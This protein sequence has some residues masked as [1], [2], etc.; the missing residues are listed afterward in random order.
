MPALTAPGLWR[1]SATLLCAVGLCVLIFGVRTTRSSRHAALVIAAESV[2]A[3]ALVLGLAGRVMAFGI[4]AVM[5]GAIATIHFSHGF[6]MNWYGTATGEG[7]EYHLLAL[8]L[9]AIVLV[10]GSGRYSLDER[11]T[12]RA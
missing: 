1:L 10:S 8:T 7:F 12:R 11:L 3:L 5:V 6:F 2:G 4:G 9:A